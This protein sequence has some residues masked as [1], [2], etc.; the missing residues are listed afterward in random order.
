MSLKCLPGQEAK[1]QIFVKYIQKKFPTY[2][3]MDRV[4]ALAAKG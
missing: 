2:T 1:A 4:N 3:G